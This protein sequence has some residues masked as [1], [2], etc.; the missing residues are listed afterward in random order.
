MIPLATCFD[1]SRKKLSK[2]E[3]DEI[4]DIRAYL[5]I[6]GEPFA[7]TQMPIWDVPV[8]EETDLATSSTA[9]DEPDNAQ[10]S[11]PLSALGTEGI[12]EGGADMLSLGHDLFLHLDLI[13][14]SARCTAKG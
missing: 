2:K 9:I 14:R 5:N 8:V 12:E 10:A 7:K 13:T 4:A 1:V 6:E 3:K 11:G